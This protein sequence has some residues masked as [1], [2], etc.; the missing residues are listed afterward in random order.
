M[1]IH[2]CSPSLKSPQI[3]STSH[4][5]S[6]DCARRSSARPSGS[7]RRARVRFPAY[8]EWYTPAANPYPSGWGLRGKIRIPT[9]CRR[10]CWIP[11]RA[12]HPSRGRRGQGWP[13]RV[14]R[15]RRASAVMTATTTSLRQSECG[16]RRSERQGVQISSRFRFVMA[17]YLSSDEPRGLRLRVKIMALIPFDDFK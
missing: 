6:K 13:S 1:S 11:R 17:A 8:R 16:I 5:S 15:R 9:T 3:V 2:D 7:R 14:G 10:R 12:R 4:Y